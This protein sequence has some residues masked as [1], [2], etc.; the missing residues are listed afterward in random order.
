[1]KVVV[2]WSG[3]KDSCLACYKALQQ[4]FA[5]QNLLTMMNSHGN[6]SFHMINVDLLD[7][8][9]YA[10]GLPLV[11]IFT[12]PETYEQDFKNALNQT[13]SQGAKGIVTGDIFDVALHEKGWLE[14]VCQ[15]TDMEPIKPLWR[16]DSRQILDEF[17]KLGFKAIVVRTKLGLLGEEF[18]GRNLDKEFQYDLS[19]LDSVDPCGERGE[20]HTLVT[21]GPLFKKRIELLQTRKSAKNGW[22]RLEILRFKLEPKDRESKSESQF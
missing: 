22:S 11:K 20:Y 12:T 21:D 7:A 3:G 18:L 1:M 4:G 19:K 16:G 6:S 17:L 9:S 10:I 8:Q 14:R 13:R 5:V 2:S 15:E